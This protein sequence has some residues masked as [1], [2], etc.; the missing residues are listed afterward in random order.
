MIASGD[1]TAAALMTRF[2]AVTMPNLG[3][4]EQ[5]AG[6]VLAYIEAQSYAANA[7]LAQDN[8]SSSTH[9]AALPNQHH[10]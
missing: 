5:D 10:H 1:A 8:A 6:D 7:M 4:S 9:P 2:P 3:L